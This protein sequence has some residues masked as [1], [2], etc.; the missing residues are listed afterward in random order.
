MGPR[1]MEHEPMG[2]SSTLD[3]GEGWGRS[4]K[5]NEDQVGLSGGPRAVHKEG[6]GLDP[7]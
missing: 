7:S 2:L 5:P 1:Q 3:E 6:L 4:M